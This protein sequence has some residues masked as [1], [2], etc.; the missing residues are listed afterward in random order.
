MAPYKVILAYDGTD[1]EG[2]QRQGSTRT[3][4]LVVENA[5]RCLNWQGRTILAAGRT[6]TGVHA[7]GQVVAFELDWAHST[8]QLGRALNANL[9]HDVSVKSVETADVDFHPR[10][11]ARARTYQYHVYCEPERHPLYDRFAWRVWPPVELQKL[12]LAASLLTGTHDF[13]AFGSPPKKGGRTERR[14]FQA[15]WEPQA[16]GLLF[17][18]TANAFLY[19]MVRRMVYLQVQAGQN[20]LELEGL[21]KAVQE[22]QPQTPGL[23]PSCGLV[24]WKVWY[25]DGKETDENLG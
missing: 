21:E 25:V 2:F 9:P 16:R 5:L 13:A 12:Q 17:E 19:H 6:D 24:L 10:F 4:Q 3:V 8:E 1:F 11:S 18:V 15:G 22:A 20:R 14:V 23:A 7:A